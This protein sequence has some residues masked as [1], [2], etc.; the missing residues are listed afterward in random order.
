[1]RP[2][3]GDCQAAAGAL[4]FGALLAAATPRSPSAAGRPALIT[5]RS[6]DGGVAA[7]VVRGWARGG[8]DHR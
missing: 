2:A 7:A 4:A 1:M 6:R 5:A 3:L 8:D